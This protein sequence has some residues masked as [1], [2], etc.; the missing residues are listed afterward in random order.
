M[1]CE[2]L[3]K[4]IRLV[5]ATLVLVGNI[6]SSPTFGHAHTRPSS[7]HDTHHTHLAGSLRHTHHRQLDPGH[8]LLGLPA[9]HDDDDVVSVADSAFHL[10]GV[11]LGIPFSL[12]NP[13]GQEA[14]RSGLL[15]LSEACLTLSTCV[16]G[17]HFGSR[18][19]LGSHVR[20]FAFPLRAHLGPTAHALH[21]VLTS[22]HGATLPCAPRTRSVM[23]RC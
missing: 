23:L 12:P 4:P 2:R 20:D 6:G 15:P 18:S 14:S 13:L 7:S 9:V 16:D 10:H 21:A 22:Q 5:L 8:A 1:R 17:S 3:M 11:W 19:P